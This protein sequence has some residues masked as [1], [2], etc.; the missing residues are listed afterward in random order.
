MGPVEVVEPF[1]LLQS[2]VEQLGIVDHDAFQHPVELLLVDPVRPLHLPV[3]PRSGRLDGNVPDLP[4]QDVVG[5]CDPNS[6]P[7]S[8]WITSTLNGSFSST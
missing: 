5:N 7:W 8:V 3:E 2:V 1:P 4:I 6:A